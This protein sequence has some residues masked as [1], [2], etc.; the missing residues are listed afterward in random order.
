[1]KNYGSKIGKL[2]LVSLF[3]ISI[4]IVFL[5]TDVQLVSTDLN[6]YNAEYNKYNIKEN[7]KIQEEE[8]IS[9]TENLLDYIKGTRDNLDFEAY[10]GGE[11]KEFFSS[12]DKEHMIDVKNIF[13]LGEIVRNIALVYIVGFK[14]FAIFRMKKWKKALS[15]YVVFSSIVGLLP[16]LILILLMNIDF[17]KYFTI[18]HEIFFTNDLWLLNPAEDML[19]NIF[20]ESFFSDTAFRIGLYYIVQLCL[21]SV[22]SVFVIKKKL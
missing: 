19:V 21:A 18:F 8:L 11:K 13:Y 20:P 4:P 15:K 12:R 22:V 3:I 10:Y 16:I 6:F 2:L 9:V 5:F 17:N 1:M 7:I 14:I